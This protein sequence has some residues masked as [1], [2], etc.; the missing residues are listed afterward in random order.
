MCLLPRPT[1][2]RDWEQI[3]TRNYPAE[4]TCKCFLINLL[5]YLLPVNYPVE[6]HL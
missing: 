1:L 6:S 5:S 2:R 3:G 4:V